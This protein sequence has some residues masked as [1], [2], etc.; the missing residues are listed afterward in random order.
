MNI[1]NNFLDKKYFD[2]L[3][4]VFLS[5]AFPWYFSNGIVDRNDG[6]IQ[7]THAFYKNN[8]VNSEHFHLLENFL[9]LLKIKSL[10]AMKLNLLPKSDTIESHTFHTDVTFKCNT[11]IFYLN[12]N[13]GKT[14][15]KNNKKID[16][17]ENKLIIFNSNLEHTGTTTTDKPYRLVLNINYF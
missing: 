7:Y 17:E 14:L 9:K 11:A 10:V 16:S 6:G 3:K 1:I 5:S 8:K 13:N 2:S 15:F 4:N 12:T